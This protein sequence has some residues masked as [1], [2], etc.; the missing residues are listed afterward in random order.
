[1]VALIGLTSLAW[2]ASFRLSEAAA[3]PAAAIEAGFLADMRQLERVVIQCKQRIATADIDNFE[4]AQDKFRALRAQ[5]KRVEPLLAYLQA[6]VTTQRL[7]GAPLPK[8]DPMEENMPSV[9]EPSGLQVIDEL[10]CTDEMLDH[11]AEIIRLLDAFHREL[12]LLNRLFASQLK[13]TDR[14][15]FE[16]CRMELIRLLTLGITG[17][18]TPGSVHAIPDARVSMDQ[19]AQLMM[20]YQPWLIEADQSELAMTLQQALE[21][22]QAFLQRREGFVSFDRMT[23]LREHLDP[24]YGLF[25]DVHLALGVETCYQ[26]SP[27]R[28]PVNYL[29]RHLFDD[30]FFD[31]DAFVKLD[32][33]HNETA[34][35]KI[36]LG[37][38]LF[39]DPVLS[40][41]VTRTCA[42]CHQ[43]ERGFTDGLAKSVATGMQGT[44]SRNAPTLTNAVFSDR[45]FHDLRSAELEMQVDHVVFSKQEFNTNYSE[46]LRR[47]K[48]SPEYLSLFY[49]AYP[50]YEGTERPP[51]NANTVKGAL[52]AYVKSLSSFNSPFDR[53]VR[54]ETDDIDPA[55][56]RGF[57]VFM[58]KGACGTCHFA[59]SFHGTVPPDYRES[60][61]EVLGVPAEPLWQQAPL[62]P[63]QGRAV[64][65]VPLD[66]AG[67]FRYSF[68]TPTVRNVAL[69]AP[70]MHNGVYQTLEEVMKFYQV[71]GGQGI[72]IHLENQT[73]P[74][75]QLDLSPRDIS[76]VIAFMGSLTDTTGMTAVPARLPAF[77]ETSPYHQR[78]I[79]GTY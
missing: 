53:Y 12:T 3:S 43:P 50:R 14:Q 31:N 34:A 52:A 32:A 56:A 30:D 58:G 48:S 5:Y 17:F 77:P 62:D 55:V 68:K 26:M 21:A 27:A 11:R 63:D 37:R 23:F 24:L 18:D 35:E 60:E 15:V 4:S 36:E 70:Y 38:Y 45:F 76:D 73:L 44:V 29:G 72:G 46:L 20:P 22:A 75:D 79:G 78:P 10:V 64:N 49:A 13:L 7:N 33:R 41:S 74:F 8:I 39:F 16:A 54:G 67:I 51:I 71:G 61:S 57:N 6:E 69:T 40:S 59:P 1:M 9:I 19:V 28:Q 66:A 2:L 65:G 42:S 47:L 25:L